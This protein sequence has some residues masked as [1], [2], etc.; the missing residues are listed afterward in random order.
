MYGLVSCGAVEADWSRCKHAIRV[1]IGSRLGLLAEDGD[2][3]SLRDRAIN[4]AFIVGGVVLGVGVVMLV[5]RRT[6][7]RVAELE[8]EEEGVG[9]GLDEEA[10]DVEASSNATEG[11]SL[12]DRVGSTNQV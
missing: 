12:I 7:A 5:Y 9:S 3:M 10:T 6:M 2:K 4:W 8:R 1:F 11:S